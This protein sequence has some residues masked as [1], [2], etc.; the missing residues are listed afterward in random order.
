M[1]F[2]GSTLLP[3]V[4]VLILC[5][6]TQAHAFGA[7]NIASTSKIE[8]SN[9]RHGD[10]ED[11]LLTLLT[12]RAMGGRKFSKLDVKR[13]YFGNWLRDYS[14]AVDV[15]TVKYVS[16]EAIRL[17]LWILG[18]MSFGF[19]TG[20]FEVTS[21]RLG[22]YRPEEHIDNPKDYAENEDATQ[23]DERL[24][25]PV[26]EEAEL[27]VDERTGMK[28]Y[29][30][31]ED[32]GITTSAGLVRKL[33]G[34]SIELGRRYKDSGDERDF[35]EALRLMGTAC[36]CL[37]DYS[38]H[39]NYTELALIELGERGVFPH[40]GRNTRMELP[41]VEHEVYPIVTGTFGGVDFLH[42]VMGEFS[43]KATQSELQELEGTLQQSQQADTSMLGEI[44]DKLPSGLLGGDDKKHQADELQAHA[45]SAQMQNM[46]ITPKEP[47]AF[48]EQM[49]EISKQIYPIL[50]FHDG[51]MKSITEA[52]DKV[53]VLPDLIEELQNQVSLFVFSLLAPFVMP[54]IKQVQEELRTGSS[55]VIQSSKE[56]QLIVFHDDDSSDPTHSML[57]KDH[58]S[59]VLNEPAGK[60]ASKVIE[61]VVPQI[62]QAW[63]D[64]DIEI[65]RTL[66]RIV[67]GVLHHPAQ[68]AYGRD[69]AR[70]GRNLMFEVVERWWTE[71]LSDDARD[72][73]REQLSREGVREGKNHKEGVEDSGHGCGKPLGLP[74]SIVGGLAGNFL[75]GLG[76]GGGG[77]GDGDDRRRRSDSHDDEEVD[78]T[79]YERPQRYD[80]GSYG[81]RVTE[82]AHRYGGGRRRSD[83]DE[84]YEQSQ[85]ERREYPSG[86]AR[87][88][89]ARYEQ[90]GRDAQGGGYGFEDSREERP[91]YGGGYEERRER[92][93][94]EPGGYERRVYEDRER[95]GGYGGRVRRASGGYEEGFRGEEAE[96]G[97]GGG[98]GGGGYGN[99]GGYASRGGYGQPP[100]EDE[101]ERRN[102]D[103]ERRYGG[104][105]GG[106]GGGG[107]GGYGGGYGGGYEERRW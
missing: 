65:P 60:V 73:L 96:F 89:F 63:D 45:Q 1:A 80:D 105:G 5:Y 55:E 102:D 39:S 31:S 34:R 29:I 87:E 15:G 43:D 64:E 42:S 48:T 58:F 30:A 33:F 100:V 76:G 94:E 61:W 17:L 11:T 90:Y 46:T 8:G 81:T 66:D 95:E 103:Y 101:Y 85:Y 83:E 97:G 78:R 25:G 35:Y 14:Q 47:E 86:G 28:R 13:V 51:I 2:K 69:G 106:Y 27:S 92:R 3:L 36:H 56:K 41:G 49:E 32:A 77:G 53:P 67:T 22:C 107:D 104:S 79:R 19:G 50:E 82:T 75:G 54:I 21:K 16:A 23:Y 37:E 62:V 10:I 12:A 84:Q 98:Y 24:R 6:A 59:N 44:L 88:D 9:W 26:D 38:A 99:G 40:V 4:A 57:S 72:E 52:I 68:R 18:F 71:E 91:L 74:S 20:E 70:E 7:G 93:F